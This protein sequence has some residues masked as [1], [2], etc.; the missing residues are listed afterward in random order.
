MADAQPPNTAHD[1][2][3]P[4]ET[5]PDETAPTKTQRGIRAR[6]RDELTREIK[7]SA[8]DQLATAGA[9][10]L[11]LRAIAR[12]LDMASSAIYRYF[13]SRDDLLTALII[14]AYDT[15]GALVE[16]AEAAVARDDH[17][18]R[19]RTIGTTLR[20]W[21]KENPHEYALIYGS[22]VPG[23][24]APADTI[25]PATRIPA[26]MLGLLADVH[27]AGTEPATGGGDPEP[28]DADGDLGFDEATLAELRAIGAFAEADLPPLVVLDGLRAWGEVFG[29]LSLELFGHFANVI[30]DMDAFFDNAL[31]RSGRAIGAR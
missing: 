29:L 28:G 18:G 12:D 17:L 3:P 31:E 1:E 10:A 9:D 21:A 27:A 26:V 7:R 30:T 15:V 6:V 25:G 2:T 4:D 5:P 19:W 24:V 20:T 13:A 16:T 8:R 22:P 11:S 23:Y 14:D